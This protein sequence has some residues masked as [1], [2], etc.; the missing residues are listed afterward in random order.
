MLLWLFKR[1]YPFLMYIGFLR[2]EK[3][4]L[5]FY[6]AAYSVSGGSVRN[7]ASY[8]GHCSELPSAFLCG[9]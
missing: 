5:L 1:V 9:I 2:E 8:A 6:S 3:W 7:A 4:C